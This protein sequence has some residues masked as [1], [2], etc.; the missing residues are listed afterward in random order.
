MP[1]TGLLQEVERSSAEEIRE[2]RE[3]TDA[4][5]RALREDA[6]LRAREIREAHLHEAERLAETERMKTLFQARAD[7]S[8]RIAQARHDVYEGAFEEAGERLRG[9]RDRPDYPAIFQRLLQEAVSFFENRDLVLHVDPADEEICRK[10]ADGIGLSGEILS[11]IQCTG[12]VIVETGGG[13]VRVEN[14]IDS[15]LDRA[16]ESMK[17]EVFSALFGD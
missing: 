5:I 4:E 10:A 8:S 14:T 16:R 3:R 12:G 11:D 6:E 9:I 17:T 13:R 2:I 15:R 1:Y 7:V